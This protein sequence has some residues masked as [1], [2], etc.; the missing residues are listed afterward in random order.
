MKGV[1]YPGSSPAG[2][3]LNCYLLFFYSSFFYQFSLASLCNF[4]LTHLENN[5]KMFR[6]LWLFVYLYMLEHQCILTPYTG[7]LTRKTKTLID[8]EF[9]CWL[10]WLFISK[11]EWNHKTLT[12]PFPSQH[13]TTRFNEFYRKRGWKCIKPDTEN[14]TG[15]KGFQ[16]S[17]CI[18]AFFCSK[19]ECQ[20][21]PRGSPISSAF[22]IDPWS[23]ECWKKIN[24]VQQLVGLFRYTSFIHPQQL[25]QFHWW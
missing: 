18:T 23:P 14:Y 19:R 15:L 20:N 21:L 3:D 7:Y 2:L 25:S 24:A 1:I 17:S 4:L 22:G 11:T 12:F 10:N 16:M 6:G 5:I 13:S 9:E 8:N